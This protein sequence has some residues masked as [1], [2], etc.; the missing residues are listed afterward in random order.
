MGS[1]CGSAVKAGAPESG[2]LGYGSGGS[3]EVGYVAEPGVCGIETCGGG[4]HVVGY[5]LWR[6]RRVVVLVGWLAP[7]FLLFSRP[8]FFLKGKKLT[9][10]ASASGSAASAWAR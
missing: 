7:F 9:L 6:E 4:F 8:L 2:I 10:T 5:E 3:D 1:S